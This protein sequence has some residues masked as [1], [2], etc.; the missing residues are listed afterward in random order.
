MFIEVS[1]PA[2]INVSL[3]KSE[4]VQ[5]YQPLARDFHSMYQMAVYEF[6]L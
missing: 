4:K 2:N 1:C 5:K 3:K 6:L